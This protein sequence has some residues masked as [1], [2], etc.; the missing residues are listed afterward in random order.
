MCHMQVGPDRF[1]SH[2]TRPQLF[3]KQ[4]NRIRH[5]SVLM[6]GSLLWKGIFWELVFQWQEG[7]HCQSTASGPCCQDSWLPRRNTP[8]LLSTSTAMRKTCNSGN[9]NKTNVRQISTRNHKGRNVFWKAAFI[10]N[11]CIS[12]LLADVC[13]SFLNA[14]FWLGESSFA[15]KWFHQADY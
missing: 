8:R 4:W 1:G 9:L 5:K 3:W 6:V 12:K 15:P 7:K 10:N 14:Q 13:G 2:S 11:L